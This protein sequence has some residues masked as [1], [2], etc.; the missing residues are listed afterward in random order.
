MLGKIVCGSPVNDAVALNYIDNHM[1][2]L[3]SY[4]DPITQSRLAASGIQT[5]NIY[6]LLIYIFCNIDDMLVNISHSDL[7]DK[8]IDVLDNMLVNTIVKAIY[9]RFYKIESKVSKLQDKIVRSLLRISSRQISNIYNS[10]IVRM[11]PS[12]YN[13]NWLIS[14]GIKKIRQ[15]GFKNTASNSLITA[16]EHRFS[17]SFAS[18]ESLIAFSTSSPDKGG[19]INPYQAIDENGFIVKEKYAEQADEITKYLPYK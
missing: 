15:G 13:D 6:D 19:S 9:Y 3:N 2:S 17:P 7:Y 5:N 16:P 18:V 10:P 12:R 8:R 11:S 4:L 14:I 1:I